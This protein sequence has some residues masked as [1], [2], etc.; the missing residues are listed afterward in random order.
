MSENQSERSLFLIDLERALEALALALQKKPKT[1]KNIVPYCHDLSNA[2][3]GLAL[4]DLSLAASE[5]ADIFQHPAQGKLGL[6]VLVDFQ[7]LVATCLQDHDNAGGG[8]SPLEMHQNT[9]AFFK[10]IH[11][12]NPS[13]ITENYL[14]QHVQ[15]I[16]VEEQGVGEEVVSVPDMEETLVENWSP[17]SDAHY[18]S[19]EEMLNQELLK[20]DLALQ[21]LEQQALH[22]QVEKTPM[23][24][25]PQEI[26]EDVPQAPLIT[27]EETNTPSSAS[28]V[29]TNK[30]LDS[31]EASLN[32]LDSILQETSDLKTTPD[33]MSL[34]SEE[35]QAYEDEPYFIDFPYSKSNQTIDKPVT[36]LVPEE[37]TP[38]NASELLTQ[39]LEQNQILDPERNSPPVEPELEPEHD[40]ISYLEMSST[41]INLETEPELNSEP[42][43]SW[44]EPSL[45]VEMTL[46][47]PSPEAE[48]SSEQLEPEPFI[49]TIEDPLAELSK[50]TE[51]FSL[52][53]KSLKT[54]AVE[55]DSVSQALQPEVQSST[56]LLASPSKLEQPSVL[57]LQELDSPQTIRD[58]V[59]LADIQAVRD[60]E[61]NSQD[62]P[63]LS[64]PLNEADLVKPKDDVS[65]SEQTQ[66]A[67]SAA[68]SNLVPGHVDFNFNL[69]KSL[70]R[71]Q[72]ARGMLH[73]PSS[74]SMK[75][76]DRLIEEQQNTLTQSVQIPLSQA[77]RGLADTVD[78]EE[79]FADP[80]IVQR[81]LSVLSILPLQQ[82]IA[83]VQQHLLIF[84]DLV[85]PKP[86][87]H[88][89]H[90]A[91]NFLAQISGSIEVQAEITRVTVPSSLLRMQMHCYKRNEDL[92]AVP[93]AQ[94]VESHQITHED[95]LYE[96]TMWDVHGSIDGPHHRIQ[97]RCGATLH[98][99]YCFETI[100]DQTVNIFDDIPNP[101][102]KP[103]WLG[104][105]GVD[106]SNQ[107]YHCLF[108]DRYAK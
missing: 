16:E 24:D 97:L 55:S 53:A 56:S 101:I 12:I 83:A 69:K 100:G 78:V 33:E 21:N 93:L 108:L 28:S 37:T 103:V 20:E 66:T 76:L 44:E 67:K 39:P 73:Q 50:L 87:E 75:E 30:L 85:G 42:L 36:A 68:K 59:T 29:D 2:L 46:V 102:T 14:S 106:G 19:V 47:E 22:Q 23:E 57:D 43:E 3:D 107:V 90:L 64:E 71:L 51:Q 92:Y 88:Q 61:P 91:G 45:S 80:N 1:T 41:Q 40:R 4:S 31:L 11:Q 104:G 95:A 26:P 62:T 38:S 34:A 27:Q 18:L 77:F 17:P 13:P 99:I 58:R 9:L 96:S 72:Q 32:Q 70:N 65:Y 54:Q 48:K 60:A 81:V 6:Q 7:E 25:V 52:A 74:W 63:S 105:M 8:L 15:T 35:E 82:H 5:L 86:S 89:L 79:I 84:I 94:L 10:K 49:E 98:S